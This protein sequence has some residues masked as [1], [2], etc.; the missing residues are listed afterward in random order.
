MYFNFTKKLEVIDRQ[1]WVNFTK[2]ICCWDFLASKLAHRRSI[3]RLAFSWRSKYSSRKTLVLL[4]NISKHSWLK[5]DFKNK[6][7]WLKNISK[8]NHKHMY[9]INNSKF[10][11]CKLLTLSFIA[12]MSAHDGL[13]FNNRVFFVF[14]TK[15]KIKVFY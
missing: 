2:V 5:N 15:S 9:I 4:V 13:K 8:D 3:S 10:Q 11:S 14:A 7:R 12:E 1:T 6:I